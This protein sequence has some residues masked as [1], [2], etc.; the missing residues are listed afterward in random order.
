[1]VRTAQKQAVQQVRRCAH[2]FSTRRAGQQEPT[3]QQYVL[4]RHHKRMLHMLA[5]V[6][7]DP[8]VHA[9]VSSCIK[10]THVNGRTVP[11]LSISL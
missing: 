7:S 3:S 10:S 11:S 4:G 6:H 1:M 8:D 5:V 9:L 2:S